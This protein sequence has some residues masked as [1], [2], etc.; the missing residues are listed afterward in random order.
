MGK[1]CQPAQKS[2]QKF[3]SKYVVCPTV[4][5]TEHIPGSHNQGPLFID[6]AKLFTNKRIVFPARFFVYPECLTHRSKNE[7]L[8]ECCLRGQTVSEN[9]SW[10]TSRKQIGWAEVLLFLNKFH[11]KVFIQ[12]YE[13]GAKFKKNALKHTVSLVTKWEHQRSEG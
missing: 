10:Y 2:A 5:K 12:E 3:A 6:V 13:A 9:Y 1:H 7:L 11:V 8:E 4:R